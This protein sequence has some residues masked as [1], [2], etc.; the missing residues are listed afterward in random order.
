[1]RDY[2]DGSPCC[3]LG[4][5]KGPCWTHAGRERFLNASRQESLDLEKE[6]LDLVVLANLRSS[7][8]RLKV[9]E[10]LSLD[11]LVNLSKLQAY[12]RYYQLPT[13]QNV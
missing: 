10:L 9:R 13:L 2:F 6:E 1:M 11:R 3:S 12:S 4:P 7:R 5:E 8:S